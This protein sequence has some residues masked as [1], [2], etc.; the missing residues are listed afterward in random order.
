MYRVHWPPGLLVSCGSLALGAI[1]LT[2]GLAAGHGPD[3]GHD[4]DDGNP[5]ERHLFVWAGDQA[6]RAPDFLTVV[7]FE[8][9][10]AEY[11]GVTTTEPVP[12]A[13]ASGNEPHHVGLS[14]D[15][16]IL[17]AGGL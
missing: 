6:R 7:N 12:G 5:R 4:R 9:G 14:R 2:A 8:E 13:G 15:G 17:A 1:A 11:G 10:A 16:N 3:D